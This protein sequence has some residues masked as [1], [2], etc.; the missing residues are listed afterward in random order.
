MPDDFAVDHF[1]IANDRKTLIPFI[2]AAQTIRPDLK[3]RASPWSLPTPMQRP[4][5]S[6]CDDEPDPGGLD[7][8]HLRLGHAG[9]GDQH[10]DFIQPADNCPR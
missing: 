10:I 1:G 4:E 3:L 8:G 2:R 7:H 9:V 5:R 6:V